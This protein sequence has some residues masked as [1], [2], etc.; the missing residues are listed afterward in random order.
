[1]EQSPAWEAN[2]FWAT[3]K[4]PRI[5]GNPKVHY[6]VYKCPPTDPILSQIDPAHPPHLTSWKSI[7]ILSSHLRLGLPSGLFP[8]GFPTKTLY[9]P[10]LSP[11]RATRPT[12]LILHDS[13]IRTI[14]GEEYRSLSSSLCSFCSFI[15]LIINFNLCMVCTIS[16]TFDNFYVSHTSI[17]HIPTSLCYS[18]FIIA[19]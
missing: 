13:I 17:L 2:R 12:P 16:S 11:I 7:L 1:M 19:Y 9:T 4:I 14:L 3:Q 18:C 5:L 8:S 6:Q 15:L 10:L